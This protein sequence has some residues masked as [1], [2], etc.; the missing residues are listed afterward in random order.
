[1]AYI[2]LIINNINGKKYVGQTIQHYKERWSKHIN[3]VKTKEGCPLLKK[4]FIKYG[5]TNFTFKILII[6]FDEDR[7]AYEKEYVK[8]YNTVTPN[9][10]NMNAGGIGGLKHTEESKAKITNGLLEYYK[11]TPNGKSRINI[12]NHR[13]AMSTAVGKKIHQIDK[14]TKQILNTYISIQEASR[15][16]GVH[17]YTIHR[18]IYNLTTTI[19]KYI[20]KLV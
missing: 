9:G 15:Q 1:M 6:C 16:S 13:K 11:N 14:N 7:I 18:N 8:K 19:G 4:A 2:Y 5:I 17:R 3:S 10:Y 12:E 20:W